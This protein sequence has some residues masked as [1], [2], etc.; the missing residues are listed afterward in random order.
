VERSQF[1]ARI[2]QRLATP[3][4]ANLPHPLAAVEGIPDIKPT[5]PIG[6][7]VEA[8]V[9]VAG[10]VGSTVRT[11]ASDD[12]LEALLDEV[13]EAEHVEAATLSRDP[14]TEGVGDRLKARGVDIVGFASPRG[15]A[16]VQL[17]VVGAAWGIAATGTT[18]FD[19]ARAGGR[20]ASLVPPA[21]LI[22]LPADRILDQPSDLFRNMAD[23]FAG[24]PPSQFVLASGPSR[25]GDIEL[26]LTM[27]V[28]GP[29]SVWVA[30]LAGSEV[31]G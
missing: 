7:S 10:Q 6:E 24:G 2:E 31:E 13:C 5:R 14:E 8:F 30:V 9:R 11:V 27:G 20:T 28:H 17:G 15:I 26:V 18:V 25:T 29:R 19:A 3:A 23:R 12:D 22:L 1:L 16:E 4:P 21:I